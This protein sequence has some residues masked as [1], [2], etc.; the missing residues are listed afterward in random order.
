MLPP[1]FERG[2]GQRRTLALGAY[3]PRLQGQYVGD[4]V[5]AATPRGREAG[6]IPALSRNGYWE[7]LP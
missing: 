2:R 7:W 1:E 3:R 4:K 5:P 6:E